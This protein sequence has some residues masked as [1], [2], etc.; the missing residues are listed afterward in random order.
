MGVRNTDDQTYASAINKQGSTPTAT[1]T[2]P[3]RSPADQMH[4]SMV[5]KKGMTPAASPI[6]PVRARPS[7]MGS[8]TPSSSLRRD[9]PA[10]R[11]AFRP[12]TCEGASGQGESW[13]NAGL[14]SN[15]YSSSQQSSHGSPQ[16]ALDGDGPA[17]GECCERKVRTA[18]LCEAWGLQRRVDLSRSGHASASAAAARRPTSPLTARPSLRTPPS[19]PP[20]LVS[21]RPGAS[22]A[23]TPTSARPGREKNERSRRLA[24]HAVS[25]GPGSPRSAACRQT[26]ALAC[27]P[28]SP[29]GAPS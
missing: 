5:N 24:R 23:A 15:P 12:P 17:F 29:R 14:T 18:L 16:V 6:G 4:A 21:C 22:P 3:Q 13:P 27:Q 9:P 20:A 8:S 7:K 10:R 28:D 11:S 26:L 2:A 1:P 25:V 19:A